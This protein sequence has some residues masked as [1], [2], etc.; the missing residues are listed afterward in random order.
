MLVTALL[1]A[2]LAAPVPKALKQDPMSLYEGNWEC[3]SVDSGDGPV[4]QTPGLR[5]AFGDGQMRIR[6]LEGES[7]STARFD[8][9]TTPARLLLTNTDPAPGGVYRSC[10]SVVKVERDRLYWCHSHSA[11][12]YPSEFKGKKPTGGGTVIACFVFE[13]VKEK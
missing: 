6:G 3:V 9:T 10:A 7:A 12:E 4:D 13:R 5:V 1:A 11:D 8:F 2:T